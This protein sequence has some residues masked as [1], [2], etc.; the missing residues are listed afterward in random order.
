[1]LMIPLNGYIGKVTRTLQ[2]KQMKQKDER[3]KVMNEVCPMA[4]HLLLSVDHSRVFVVFTVVV[5]VVPSQV[6]NGI[7]IIKLYAWERPF[8]ERIT[9]VLI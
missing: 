7:K 8:L 3:I 2:V 6:L 1:M 5:V 9:Q 4:C